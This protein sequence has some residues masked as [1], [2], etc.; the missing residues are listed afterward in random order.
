MWQEQQHDDRFEKQQ[1][2]NKMIKM[3]SVFHDIQHRRQ[4]FDF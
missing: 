2:V 4:I 1:L 3:E